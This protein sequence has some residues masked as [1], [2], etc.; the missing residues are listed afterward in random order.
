MGKG[1]LAGLSSRRASA[2]GGRCVGVVDVRKSGCDGDEF[3]L[4]N[5]RGEAGHGGA[6]ESLP[7]ELN[8]SGLSRANGD[9]QLR[10]LRSNGALMKYGKT[11]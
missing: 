10:F 7:G 2:A 8:D 4:D 1:G 5:E 3:R 6:D 11:K 9:W